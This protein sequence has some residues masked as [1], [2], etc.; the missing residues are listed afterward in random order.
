M[1][2]SGR[3]QRSSESS[4]PPTELLGTAAVTPRKRN[5]PRKDV[6]YSRAKRKRNLSNLKIQTRF[7]REDPDA[8]S[9][10]ALLSGTDVT[11]SPK[12]NVH[13]HPV[14]ALDDTN[15]KEL[16]GP[17]SAGLFQPWTAPF[18]KSIDTNALGSKVYSADEMTAMKN[19]LA[20][21]KLHS[22]KHLY[23]HADTRDPSSPVTPSKKPV[24]TLSPS[25]SI[26]TP[27]KKRH[28]GT[29]KPRG[30]PYSEKEAALLKSVME[31]FT[32]EGKHVGDAQWE[33]IH[34]RM[35][36][37]GVDRP[38]H[39]LRMAWSRRFRSRFGIDERYTKD[40]E[41]LTTSLLTPRKKAS[42][43]VQK[44][45]DATEDEGENDK[46]EKMDLE[47]ESP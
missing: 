3:S 35:K 37:L 34:D 9:D 20:K 19:V 22:P 41:N 2:D 17:R 45:G 31:E 25:S 7:G 43:N 6:P 10:A 21:M 46:A 36:S 32:A 15:T 40:S 16:W 12:R 5:P 38:V 27:R 11:K 13:V 29:G 42:A 24:D 23:E 1:V 28:G 26:S 47:S 18:E 8:S 30:P 14:S 33:Q 39:G 44:G 4:S